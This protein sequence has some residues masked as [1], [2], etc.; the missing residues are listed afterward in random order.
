MKGHLLLLCLLL[1]LVASSQPLVKWKFN[2]RDIAFGQAAAADID[3]DGKL[4]VVFGCYRND[5]CVYALNAENGSLLWK[6]NAAG[7]AEGCNDTA[8]L[9]F[10]VDGDGKMEV[11]AAASCNPKTFCLNGATGTV[12]WTCPTRGSDS[13]PTVADIDNDGKP[14]ILHGEF[15]GYVLCINAENGSV[16]WELPVDTDSWIQTAPTIADLDGDG[17]PDFIVATWNAV[18]YAANKVYAFRGYDRKLLWT[19]VLSDVVYHGTAVGD[20]DGDGKA[21]LLV[22]CYNDT[23]Y[24]LNGRTGTTKWTYSAGSNFAATSPA[25]I[26]DLDDDGACEVVFAAWYKMIA[27]R[28]DGGLKW[29]YNMPAYSQCFRGPAIADLSNDRYPDVVFGTAAGDLIALHGENGSLLFQKSLRTDYGDSLFSFDHAPLIADFDRDGKLDVFI[30][31]GHG[32]Y[33]DF[34]K[35]FGRA[36]ML[37]VGPGR[38]PDWL[39]FQHDVQRRGNAC[40]GQPTGIPNQKQEATNASLRIT[41]DASGML[42]AEVTLNKAATGKLDV[43]N[44]WGQ[45]VFE[46]VICQLKSGSNSIELSMPSLAAGLY[47]CRFSS[48]VATLTA[49]FVQR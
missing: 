25:L 34:F 22:G 43:S 26:A 47:F 19:H 37:S 42:R 30:A 7:S 17:K 27:L 28:G 24:C 5:S 33:P 46:S 31:G 49:R 4:E 2:T 18:N 12:K 23:L 38:G 14:E 41:A 21:E 3:K 48:D 6:F 44:Q 20:L 13:P 45:R 32:E 1:R 15:D 40:N 8:P 39:M 16:A 29:T 10:D 11:I 9:L 35:D 36:Y